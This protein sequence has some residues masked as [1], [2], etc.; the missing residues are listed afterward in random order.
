MSEDQRLP[1]QSTSLL[2][3]PVLAD[4]NFVLHAWLR[5][6]YS[7]AGQGAMQFLSEALS[8]LGIPTRLV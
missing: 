6:G 2:L 5:I 4:G 8:L 7:G 1:R 3:L